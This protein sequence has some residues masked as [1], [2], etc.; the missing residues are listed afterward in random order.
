MA[1]IYSI[2]NKDFL[3]EFS[4]SGA[5]LSA[6]GSIASGDSDT[7]DP[8]ELDS[9]TIMEVAGIQL[10]G[11]VKN[12][13][14][15]QK[16]EHVKLKLDTEIYPHVVFNEMMAP[17]INEYTSNIGP[18]F[19]GVVK[20]GDGSL[21]RVPQGLCFNLG[22]PLLMGGDPA[23]ACPKLGPRDKLAFEV[24][25]PRT[26][27]GGAT[28]DQDLIVRAT[29]VEVKGEDVAKRVLEHYDQLVGA[30]VKQ[31]FSIMDLESGESKSVSKTVPF[32]LEGWVDL[33]GG[34]AAGRPYIYP[35]IT[36]AQ[37]AKATTVN[38]EYTFRR[39]DSRV[40]QDFMELYWNYNDDEAV[41]ISHMGVLTHAYLKE[42]RM[43]IHGKTINPWIVTTETEN[44]LP[45]GLHPDANVKEYVG[46]VELP[47][48][49]IVWNNKGQIEIKDN[50]TTGG[51]AAW[52]SGVRGAMVALWGKYYKF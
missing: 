21:M 44:E 27:E 36:Y 4:A 26:T 45:L 17:P 35:Y 32:S 28:V 30:D 13:G 46:P 41:T 10:I 51:I 2:R 9:D 23:N 6:G 1:D 49:F 24:K 38:T 15:R 7:T 14:T 20:R 39:Q 37:N 3:F 11:P 31:S 12:D 52:A 25:V 48:P 47:R 34:L 22:V 33:H 50:G 5:S 8:Y 42:T 19:G 43:Y 40:L 18:F 29:I 16:L